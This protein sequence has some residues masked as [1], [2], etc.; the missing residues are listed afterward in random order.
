MVVFVLLHILQV[1]GLMKLAEE[2]FRR[3][4]SDPAKLAEKQVGC[5]GLMQC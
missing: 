2:K 4:L 5:L 3:L 1:D